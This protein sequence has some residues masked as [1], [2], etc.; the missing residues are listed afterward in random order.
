M[1]MDSVYIREHL[2]GDAAAY[3]EWQTDLCVARYVSW[4]PGTR[5]DA[6][7]GLLDAIE[8]QS[9]PDR[10]RYFFAVVMVENEEV[11][12]DVGF[13]L[14]EPLTADC[15]WFLRRDFQGKGFATQ[16]V[17]QLIRYAFTCR[18]LEVLTASCYRVNEASIRIM[19]SCGFILQKESAT[20]SWYSQ[21]LHDRNESVDQQ[22]AC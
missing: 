11:I 1:M 20:R 10:K 2:P 19:N 12:G 13:T 5:A 22:V 7:A 15:G 4:L 18:K 9:D 16:A 14:S 6:E 17:S 21:S 3:I 8:Q